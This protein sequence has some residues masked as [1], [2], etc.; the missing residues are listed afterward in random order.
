MYGPE[1][2]VR[3]FAHLA[4]SAL[5]LLASESASAGQRIQNSQFGFELTVPDG[6]QPFAAAV[7]GD[8]IYA[9]HKPPAR[10][11]RLGFFIVIS[12]M[13]GLLGR[14]KIGP[15]QLERFGKGVTVHKEHWKLKGLD[16]DVFRVP[17]SRDGFDVVTFNV[18]VPLKPEAIQ[19]TVSGDLADEAE[20][21]RIVTELRSNLYG[22]SNWLTTAERVGRL[23]TGLLQFTCCCIDP[24]IAI[25]VA[26][27]VQMRKPKRNVR[28]RRPRHDDEDDEE[29]NDRR[30]R[31]DQED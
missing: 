24:L 21:Q 19:I 31:D 18:Q 4:A 27:V 22:Q 16:V 3:P 10:D 5:L 14:E 9:F 7:R 30:R 23:I 6:F 25:V 1:F 12:R 2:G 13:K 15:E 20:A 8:V 17:E 29:V 26:V 11:E 28:R